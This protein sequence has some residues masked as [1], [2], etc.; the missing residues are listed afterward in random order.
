MWQLENP[1]LLAAPLI[2]TNNEISENGKSKNYQG[3]AELKIRTSP[4]SHT[5][6]GHKIRTSPEGRSIRFESGS[7]DSFGF[8]DP[9]EDQ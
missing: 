4:E 6:E 1:A 9:G 2:Q 7:Q 3:H 5:P 8:T